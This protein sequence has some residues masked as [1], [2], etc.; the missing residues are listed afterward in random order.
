VG[1]EITGEDGF[2]LSDHSDMGQISRQPA[3]LA[4]Q[5]LNETHQYPDGAMLYL[6]TMF[7]PTKDR[8]GA[9]MG[10][11]H[12]SG[13]I[14]TVYAAELG[15][16]VNQVR[17]CNEVTPWTFGTGALMRNLAARGELK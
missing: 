12:K 4:G 8:D 9:G 14:V 10:F 17:P 3:D 13:D 1:L 16:L 15:R 6:G 7:A 5:L 11:T 2:E